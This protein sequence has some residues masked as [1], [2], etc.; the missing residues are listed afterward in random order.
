[1]FSKIAKFSVVFAAVV[2]LL[3]LTVSVAGAASGY[4]KVKVLRTVLYDANGKE[5]KTGFWNGTTL[6]VKSTK[7]MTITYTTWWGSERTKV[8]VMGLV[9][10]HAY[11]GYVVMADLAAQ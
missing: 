5:T 7:S 1:M 2:A 4:Y 8:A 6:L 11:G 3:A 10:S 9:D